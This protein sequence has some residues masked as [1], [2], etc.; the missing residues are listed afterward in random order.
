VTDIYQL[1]I[2]PD[3]DFKACILKKLGKGVGVLPCIL[4]LFHTRLEAIE[5]A[6]S[7]TGDG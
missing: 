7:S 3:M 6:A 1:D 4:R 5:R 2:P